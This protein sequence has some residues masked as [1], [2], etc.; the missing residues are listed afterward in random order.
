V[1]MGT[2]YSQWMP[3][4]EATRGRVEMANGYLWC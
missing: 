1:A 2:T 3:E 4:G